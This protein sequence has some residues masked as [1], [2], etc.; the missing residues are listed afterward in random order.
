MSSAT[1]F[2]IL[3]EVL[4]DL[5][6]EDV[7]EKLQ[8]ILYQ[9]Q[10]KVKI[11]VLMIQT[12]PDP[13]AL[14]SDATEIIINTEWSALGRYMYIISFSPIKLVCLG[15]RGCLDI[16]ITNFDREIHKMSNNLGIHIFEKLISGMYMGRLAAEVLAA[17]INQG[18]I[19][20]PQRDHKQSYRY[21]AP[22]HAL[23]M[24][25]SN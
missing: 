12:I 22:F 18:I 16:L 2:R 11:T 3:S 21:Y 13:S 17:L 10:L 20:K 14:P 7:V 25:Q 15:E 6:G 9:K 23:H 19:L 8:G 5:M 1:G 24:L 4:S